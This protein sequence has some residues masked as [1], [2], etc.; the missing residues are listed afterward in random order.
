LV[1]VNWVVW[2]IRLSIPTQVER[3]DV[4]T[5]QSATF[6]IAGFGKDFPFA[7]IV[8][9]PSAPVTTSEVKYELVFQHP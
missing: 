3:I 4:G 5:G 2:L 7:A 1:P 9:S 6:E 8:L